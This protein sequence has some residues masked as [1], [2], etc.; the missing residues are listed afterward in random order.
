MP[1]I[2]GKAPK[3]VRKMK[4]LDMDGRPVLFWKAPKGKG[5]K[6]EAVKYVVYKFTGGDEVDVDDPSKIVAVTTDEFYEIPAS[7]IRPGE[8]VHYAVTALDRMSNESKPRKK[9]IKY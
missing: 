2:D 5:W 4:I 8:K 9:S 3:K 1:Y 7:D 6:N